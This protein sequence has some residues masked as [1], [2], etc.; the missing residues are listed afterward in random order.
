MMQYRLHQQ[1]E[2][3]PPDYAESYRRALETGYALKIPCDLD[4]IR[5]NCGLP[6]MTL[7]PATTL[8]CLLLDE[9]E[10]WDE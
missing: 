9:K 6:P 7:I 2:N 5:S 3:P 10:E 8:R 1:A 4:D